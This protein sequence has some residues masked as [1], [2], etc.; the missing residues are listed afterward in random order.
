MRIAFTALL[1]A[2]GC[3]PNEEP[4]NQ[5]PETTSSQ[6][7]TTT[8]TTGTTTTTTTEVDRVPY[9][10]ASTLS[11]N[12]TDPEG[13]AYGPD[14]ALYVAMG[15][16]DRVVRVD[17][18][19]G[20][21]TPFTSSVLQDVQGLAFGPSGDLFAASRGSNWIVR[22]DG[23]TGDLID[24]WVQLDAPNSVALTADGNLY[25]TMRNA[26]AVR[27]FDE[28]GD[29]QGPFAASPQIDTPE[30]LAFGPD[31]HLYVASRGNNQIVRFDGNTGA[32]DATVTSPG[33]V[34]APES[35]VFDALGDLWVSSRDSEEVVRLDG[36][37][38]SVLQTIAMPVGGRPIGIAYDGADVW[39]VTR[40]AGQLVQLSPQSP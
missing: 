23:S 34:D 10:V 2:I 4:P 20:G 32:L 29:D 22:F 17:P 27:Q 16:M 15:S 14:G 18:N 31:G 19:T 3:T 5:K 39:V 35:I 11:L 7:G 25:V 30:G 36:S 13:L 9:A 24:P 6:T 26:S 38:F 33:D 12:D 8:T 1:L 28:N 37:N 40:D 21:M